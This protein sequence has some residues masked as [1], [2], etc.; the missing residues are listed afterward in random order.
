MHYRQC[1]EVIICQMRDREGFAELL[2]TLTA[3]NMKYTMEEI[4]EELY[5]VAQRIRCISGSNHASGMTKQFYF[6]PA[7][8]TAWI[9]TSSPQNNSTSAAGEY[10]T[11]EE[12]ELRR[13]RGASNLVHSNA[14][15]FV[16]LTI[17]SIAI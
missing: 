8:L 16:L 15:N 12:S 11:D 4:P 1:K 3:L 2:S 5:D 14:D 13:D 7:L 9:G 6:E 17:H 10:P